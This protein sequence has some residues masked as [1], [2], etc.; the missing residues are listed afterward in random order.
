MTDNCKHLDQNYFKYRLGRVVE[1]T[2]GFL[3]RFDLFQKQILLSP[4]KAQ[5]IVLACCYLHNYLR[6]RQPRTYISRNG[7]VVEDLQADTLTRKVVTKEGTSLQA[8]ASRNV[9]SSA[10]TV[11][12]TYCQ[13]FNNKGQISWQLKAVS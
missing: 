1:N 11:R 3:V 7:V 8:S 12:D 10:K 2:F 5:I 13:F 4:E 6:E 9:L